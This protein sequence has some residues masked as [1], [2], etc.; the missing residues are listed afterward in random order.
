MGASLSE[1]GCIPICIRLRIESQPTKIVLVAFNVL[2]NYE[3]ET[4]F[5]AIFHS[6]TC[7]SVGC[8][9]HIGVLGGNLDGLH[10]D[11]STTR[12][13]LDSLDPMMTLLSCGKVYTAFE[14]EKNL[15]APK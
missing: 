12:Q 6:T 5:T 3:C 15:H 11:A 2:L 10:L 14:H 1:C 8:I 13:S 7:A 9:C 4:I